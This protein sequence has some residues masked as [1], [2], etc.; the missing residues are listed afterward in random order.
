[1]KELVYTTKE[2]NR[3]F[4]IKVTGMYQGKKLHTL[5]GVKGMLEL[6]GDIDLANRVL[7]RAFNSKED[8][9][10]CKLRRGIRFDF[11]VY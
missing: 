5:V 8:K 3:N 10:T 6:I 9:C 7:K 4:K 2:I 1:M 11:Y